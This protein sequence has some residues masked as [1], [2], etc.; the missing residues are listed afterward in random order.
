MGL[1]FSPPTH[2]HTHTPYTKKFKLKLQTP[3]KILKK[4]KG[5]KKTNKTK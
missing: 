3:K 2:T 4:P 5:K 1:P